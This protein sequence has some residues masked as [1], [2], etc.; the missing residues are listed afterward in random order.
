M[1]H[2][3]TDFS[4][5]HPMRLRYILLQIAA[6]IG[7]QSMITGKSDKLRSSY[8]TPAGHNPY[9][10]EKNLDRLSAFWLRSS[11]KVEAFGV[12]RR[13]PSMFTERS[14]TR[15]LSAITLPRDILY[16]LTIIT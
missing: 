12:E 13:N 3:L 4:C 14:P 7:R 5:F 2:R 1:T 11:V 8:T 15:L 10:T 6:P 16:I 9:F